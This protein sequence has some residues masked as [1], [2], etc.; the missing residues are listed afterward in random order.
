LEV[1]ADT[2][3][4]GRPYKSG[5]SLKEQVNEGYRQ[6]PFSSE[7]LFQKTNQSSTRSRKDPYHL[8][9]TASISDFLEKSDFK[10]FGTTL[11]Y[12]RNP[13]LGKNRISQIGTTL[14][15]ARNPILGKNRISQI[16]TTLHEARNPIL[17]KNRISQIGTTLHYARNPSF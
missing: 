5:F 10:N 12:A 15:E 16:G 17:G 3:W 1:W 9:I 14:H 4:K 6:M 7:S 11:H 8:F 13:I 2:C